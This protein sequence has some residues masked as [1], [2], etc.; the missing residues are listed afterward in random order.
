MQL[1]LTKMDKN[2][3]KVSRGLNQIGNFFLLW[4]SGHD[5]N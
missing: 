2:V 5:L 1:A 3:Q 4:L